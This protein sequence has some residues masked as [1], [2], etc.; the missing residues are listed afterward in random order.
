[1]TVSRK[2][3][4]VGSLNM[5]VTL[6]VNLLPKPNETIM[7]HETRQAVGGKGLNQ[8]VALARLGCFT[9]MIGAV[10]DDVFGAQA[11]QHLIDNRV[12]VSHVSTLAGLP[13]GMAHILVARDGQNMITVS[14]G[15]NAGL[16]PAAVEAAA[17][18]I[19]EADAL[20][21]QLEVPLETVRRALEIARAHSVLTVLNPAP[22]IPSA[23]SLLPLADVVT[24]NE[25]ELA[26][27]SGIDG[28]GDAAL[29][30][31]L[32]SLIK[33]GAGRALVTLGG[34]GCAALVD[35][36]LVHLPAYKVSAV[37]ATGAGDVFNGALV[38][39]LA[40]GA[41]WLLAL[42]YALAAGALS[43]SRASADAAPTPAQIDA[44]MRE[45][46]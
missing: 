37:D 42:R 11:R 43:V 28:L 27:L 19:V 20:V 23:L 6:G 25:T 33:A 17:D 21:V 39:Q 46:A 13:T 14:P 44:F 22:I 10:G 26:Q 2:I 18:L 31:A 9:A 4:V 8:A 35:G 7:G 1:M 45:V 24:P 15:A 16:T 41:K 40:G 5:D 3:V 32:H 12:D 29:H 30:A 38:S 36:T 34:R